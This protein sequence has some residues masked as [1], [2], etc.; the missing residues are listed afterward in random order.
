MKSSMN[1]PLCPH[2]KRNEKECE[3]QTEEE[4]N[5]I[6]YWCGGWGV[7]CDDCY[8]KN[9]PEE[10]EAEARHL[11]LGLRHI[12]HGEGLEH[13]VVEETAGTVRWALVCERR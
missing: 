10:E 7:S 11:G 4:K 6:T 8:Y 1:I 12:N 13:L 2:C 5:P 3:E 9:H